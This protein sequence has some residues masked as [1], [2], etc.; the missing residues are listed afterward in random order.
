VG[1]IRLAFALNFSFALAE[2]GG[3]VWSNSLA[4]TADA[5]HDLG[6]SLA[7]GLSWYFLKLAERGRTAAFS[8]GYRRFAL[9]GALSNCM[10]LL[11]GSGWILYE[12]AR[13]LARPVEP[14]APLMLLFAVV[15]LAVNAFAAWRLHGERGLTAE[16]VRWHLLEDVLGWA[17]VLAGAV[18]MT[19][20]DVPILDPLLSIGIMLF[21]LWNVLR[22]L[23]R[24][25]VVFLQAAPE[26]LDANE[27]ER[28]ITALP[29]VRAAH[30]THVWSLDGEHHVLTTHVVLP[31]EA[32][33]PEIVEAKRRIRELIDERR[34]AHLTIEV[35]LEGET[36]GMD[37]HHPCCGDSR[38]VTP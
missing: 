20:S 34:I 23:R 11:A 18:V 6:D 33:R 4:I 8:Y 38:P 25:A 35:E 36:C 27:L 22:T 26:G 31:G 29:G 15:G 14:N 7:L 13:R 24:V 9:L 10:I 32:G 17:A 1:G 5:L 37:T 12:A 16:S 2:I 30:H 28:Q 19:F 3:G 21:I